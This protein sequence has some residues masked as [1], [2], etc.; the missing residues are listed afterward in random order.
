MERILKWVLLLEDELDEQNEPIPNDL[1]TVKEQ[2]QNHEVR[3]I[4]LI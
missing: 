1:K 3:K 2:F 4:V